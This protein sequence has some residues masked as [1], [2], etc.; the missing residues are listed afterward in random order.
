[1]KIRSTHNIFTYQEKK[2]NSFEKRGIW[3][4]TKI[5]K[6]GKKEVRGRKWKDM[7]VMY[8]TLIEGST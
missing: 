1:M 7:C 2:Q 5:E 3:E 8:G 6:M 4:T